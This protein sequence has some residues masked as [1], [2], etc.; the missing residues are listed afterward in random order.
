MF[1]NKTYILEPMK[2]TTHR[3]KLVA[4]ENMENIQGLC[5]SHHNKSSL[6][7]EGVSPEPSQM[8]AR[9]VR[10]DFKFM[11]LELRAEGRVMQL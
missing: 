4:A 10:G 1:E 9:R 7:V 3:Y 2:N 11:F 5:G 8:W 6:T